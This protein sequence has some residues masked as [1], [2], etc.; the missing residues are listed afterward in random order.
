MKI[1][2][3][4]Q[5]AISS[6]RPRGVRVIESYSPKLGRRLQCFGEDAFRQWIRLEADPSVESFCERPIYLT[7]GDEKRL[8]DFWISQHDHEALLVLDAEIQAS[9]ITIN[10]TE[11]AVRTILPVELAAARIWVGNWERMLP[12]IISC[13]LLS[14]LE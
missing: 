4:F 14:K 2:A 6:T 7:S 3:R 8:A 12:V 11:L 10:E 5:S 13:R 9:P 1:S